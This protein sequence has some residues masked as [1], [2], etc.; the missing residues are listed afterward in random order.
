MVSLNFATIVLLGAA[1][2]VMALPNG[3]NRRRDIYNYCGVDIGAQ[4]SSGGSCGC[5]GIDSEGF[6]S[7]NIIYCCTEEEEC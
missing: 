7:A 6:G 5:C 1:S 3:E 4:C 2:V